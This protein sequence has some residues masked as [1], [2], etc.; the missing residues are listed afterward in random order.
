M[1][2]EFA[3]ETRPVTKLTPTCSRVGGSSRELV[4]GNGGL[5]S[6]SQPEPILLHSDALG[7]IAFKSNDIVMVRRG[8]C[9][10]TS[11]GFSPALTAAKS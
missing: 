6:D 8:A 2:V 7:Q 9:S 4:W 10:P 1:D 5:I 3:Q 11:S